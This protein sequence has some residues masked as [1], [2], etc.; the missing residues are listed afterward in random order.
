[1]GRDWVQPT[2][3]V[4]A[5]LKNLSD[6]TVGD[7]DWSYEKDIYWKSG[8]EARLEPKFE[9]WNLESRKGKLNKS[10]S[11]EWK[12]DIFGYSKVK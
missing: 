7:S 8:F 3:D 2:H 6:R 10:F 11:T 12:I 4:K 9:R 5:R 1:M